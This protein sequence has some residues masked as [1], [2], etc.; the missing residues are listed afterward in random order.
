[1]QLEWFDITLLV[2]VLFTSIR[3]LIHGAVASIVNFL[4]TILAIYLSTLVF[5]GI[6]DGLENYIQSEL[7][8]NIISA[9]IAILFSWISLNFITK[10]IIK[11]FKTIDLGVLDKL[12]GLIFGML[13]GVLYT[14]VIMLFTVIVTSGSYVGSDNAYQLLNNINKKNLPK[15]LQG[16]Y[17]YQLYINNQQDIEEKLNFASLQYN[18]EWLQ[19]IDLTSD[20]LSSYDLLD[21]GQQPLNEERIKDEMK[22]NASQGTKD[23]TEALDRSAQ[24][25]IDSVE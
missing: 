9:I 18:K 6:Q 1:M 16:A 17:S 25:L 15:W 7:I 24:K 4:T 22:I 13:K 23:V 12:G 21:D 11:L 5:N 10:P 14:S 20:N 2:I 3:G 8:L 19:D